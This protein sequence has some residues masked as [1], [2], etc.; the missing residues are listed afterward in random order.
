M[1]Y[2]ASKIGDYI[3]GKPEGG[4]G[5]VPADIQKGLASD[6]AFQDRILNKFPPDKGYTFGSSGDSLEVFDSTGRKVFTGDIPL[7]TIDMK[8]FADLTNNGQ[9]ATP[10]ISSG[11]ISSDPMAGVTDTV[12]KRGNSGW[13]SMK[14]NTNPDGSPLTV[15]QINAAKASLRAG[16]ATAKNESARLSE[17]QIRRIFRII[18]GLPV[19]EGMWDTIKGAAG[20][21]LGA[22][23]NKA[24][25]VGKNLTTKVTAD[26]LMSAWKSAGSP[27][28]SE[29]VKAFLQQQGVDATIIDPA[30]KA[31]GAVDT[32]AATNPTADPSG[33][34]EPTLDPA[35][36][37]ASATPGAATK[38]SKVGVPA[39][40]AAVDQ[41]VNSIKSVRGDRRQ[42]VVQYAQAKF[43]GIKEE[44]FHS[45]FLGMDI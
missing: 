10:G 18:D 24:A 41:A 23:A 33:R 5:E 7:K 9:M 22:V 34:I 14:A 29:E 30:M 42:Q 8:Q 13:D 43:S 16:N 37:P 45:R 39:G 26:K 21:A 25:T 11:S 40:K 3:K 4:T 17:N 1:A 20:N 6:Q 38:A 32:P 12:A 28:E 15:D 19:N 35:T 2:G 31:V 36:P 27:T 44:K